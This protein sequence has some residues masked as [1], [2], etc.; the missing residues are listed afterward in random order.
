[1]FMKIAIVLA[2]ALGTTTGALA[3]TKKPKV[4][5]SQSVYDLSDKIRRDTYMHDFRGR[6][7]KTKKTVAH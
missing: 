3:A 6:K 7:A 1:M 2:L 4:T 5:Q